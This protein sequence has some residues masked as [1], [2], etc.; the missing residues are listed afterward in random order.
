MSRTLLRTSAVV[1]PVALLA[2]GGPALAHVSVDP[3]T[4]EGGGYTKLTF[5]VPTESDTASTTKL[6]V[7]FP[8]DQPFGSVGVQPVAGWSYRVVDKKLKTPITTDDGQVSQ[9]VSQITWTADSK[10]SA[11]RPGQFDEFSIAVGPL[12]D[13]GSLVFKVLQTY[14]DGEVARWIDPPAAG[15]AEPEHP[16]PVVTLTAAGDTTETA[17]VSA[18]DDGDSRSGWALGLSGLALVVAGA[19]AA[20]GLR[21]RA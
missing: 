17:G 8:A 10:K 7:F 3:D 4:A 14:S 9:A 18:E 1:L 15:Q 12:P 2:L 11:I 19:G 13:S 21:R 5:R 20:L 6:Q 16:A